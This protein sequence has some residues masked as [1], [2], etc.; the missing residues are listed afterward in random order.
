MNKYFLITKA[1][2]GGRPILHDAMERRINKLGKK[3]IRLELNLRKYLYKVVFNPFFYLLVGFF[4]IKKT[5]NYI[6]FPRKRLVNINKIEV[7][8]YI[9]A[10]VLRDP[11]A[12]MHRSI[13]IKRYVRYSIKG[14]YIYMVAFILK[15]KVEF[16]YL[17]DTSYL[18]GII[19]DY[20]SI[21]GGKVFLKGYPRNIVLCNKKNYF[22]YLYQVKNF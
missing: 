18:Y 13:Y 4:F 20:F 14:V 6:F 8:R 1:D 3:N 21:R 15:N 5:I 7:E 2:D 22:Y 9:I 10:A 19:S 11:S 12:C 17:H 16:V